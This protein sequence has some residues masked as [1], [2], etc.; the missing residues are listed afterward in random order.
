MKLINF[1]LILLAVNTVACAQQKSD[2][3]FVA[4]WNV[5]NLFDNIDD[6]KVIDE[7]FLSDGT[8]EWTDERIEKKL[9]SLSRIIRSM[10]DNAGPDLLGV[11]EVEHQYLLD[12]LVNNYLSDKFYK[13]SYLESPDGRGIDNGIIYNSKILT[14][15]SINGYE[16]KFSDGYDTRLILLGSFLFEK[17]D[18]IHFFVN[19]WPSRRGGEEESQPRRIKVANTLR[20]VVD[21]LLTVNSKSKIV[22]VGD[23]ND[24]PTNISITETLKAQPFFCDSI[25]HDKL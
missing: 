16:T 19:H 8:K 24:E 9:Y 4:H 13:V 12:S 1:L 6:D 3:L 25:N 7:E 18:T 15:L 21:S 10:N 14:L 5:E 2:T 20:N 23:F 17:I 11:C 22:I